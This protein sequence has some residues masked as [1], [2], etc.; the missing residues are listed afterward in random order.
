MIKLASYA[1][2]AGSGPCR[3]RDGFSQA[4]IQWIAQ[5][6]EGAWE[7]MKVLA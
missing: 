5:E 4:V 1:H 2:G 6:A 3:H 7:A